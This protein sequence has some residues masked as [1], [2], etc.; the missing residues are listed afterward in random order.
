MLLGGSE[1][2]PNAGLLLPPVELGEKAA[3]VERNGLSAMT[4]SFEFSNRLKM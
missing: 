1:D 3:K 4:R 2:C